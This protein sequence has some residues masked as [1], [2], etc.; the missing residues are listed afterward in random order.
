VVHAW[1]LSRSD[2]EGSW[3]LFSQV[4]RADYAD[5]QGG[6]TPEG[7]HLGGMAGSVDLVQRCFVGIETR[8]DELRF[9]PQLPREIFCLRLKLRYRGL[10]VEIDLDHERLQLVCT[11][12][13]VEPIRIGFGSQAAVKLC[14]GQK[15]EFTL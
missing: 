4:L 2:R 1:V 3:K 9:N 5:I 8:A 13:G 10:A 15:A 14:G 7:I 12:C 6:T 11:E